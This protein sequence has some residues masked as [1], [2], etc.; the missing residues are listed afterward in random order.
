ML[1]DRRS[2]RAQRRF[3]S[4]GCQDGANH[5]GTAACRRAKSAR[6]L[7]VKPRHHA[8][9][10]EG[11][12]PQRRGGYGGRRIRTG[13]VENARRPP[14]A[15]DRPGPVTGVDGNAG[16]GGTIDSV[17]AVVGDDSLL[18]NSGYDTFGSPGRF[19]AGPG[20]ALYVLR[21]PDA[22]AP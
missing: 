12:R 13:R 8:P 5:A 6:V 22:S 19:Q 7:V 11:P 17:G 16:Q 15:A 14:V 2:P 3:A 10:D 9:P 21:L 4:A 18:L 1:I 20:N